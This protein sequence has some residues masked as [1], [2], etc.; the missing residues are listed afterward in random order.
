M[1]RV[2]WPGLVVIGLLSLMARP[3][4]GGAQ[5]SRDEAAVVLWPGGVPGAPESASDEEV[6]ETGKG[7]ADRHVRNVHRPTLSVYLPDKETATGSGV[8]IC[9]G[10]G[11]SILAIDKE[12][13]DIARWLR[14]F[15]VAGFVLK[16]RLPR[17][18]GHVY[19]H[20][21]PLADAQRAIRLVRAKAADWGINPGRVGIMG[22]SA[23]GHLA[24][25]AATHFDRGRQDSNDAIERQH[26]R[27]DFLILVYPVVTLAENTGH[28]GSRKNLL[29]DNPSPQLIEYYSNDR[30]VTADSP[31]TFLVHTDDD[32][33]RAENSVLFYLA[34]RQ[35][36]VPAELHI[37]AK[38]GHGYGI[39]KEWQGIKNPSISSWP[40]RCQAWLSQIGML[41]Q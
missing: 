32:P 27:P 10:G 13:H 4:V 41:D 36:K 14:S 21:A 40:D 9:P 3:A 11:Y 16:Y 5:P 34:L 20:S 35:S 25:T 26:C 7:F 29:G 23:G 30:H 28:V 19:G 17:P 2:D 31:P 1:A 38:G 18:R 37:Y 12:G 24:A 15:G 39:R 33:V 6:V 22:F 8:I